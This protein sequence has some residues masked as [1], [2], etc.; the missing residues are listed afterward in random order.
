MMKNGF[1]CLAIMILLSSCSVIV[2]KIAHIKNPKVESSN[3]IINYLNKNNIPLENNYLLKGNQD[4]TTIYNNLL[5]G[6][7]SEILIFDKKGIKYCYQG[8]DKCTG[9][10]LKQA[11]VNFQNSYKPCEKDSTLL[12]TILTNFQPLTEDSNLKVSD[13]YLII[14]WNKYFGSKNKIGEDYTWLQ[15][16]KKDSDLD[17]SILLVNTDLQ[18]DW[19]LVEGKKMKIKFRLK[20]MKSASIEFGKIPYK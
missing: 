3:T 19:G 8:T 18:T 20:S 9:K 10:Q 7:K 16:M 1:Y 6:F 14:Y 15:T 11:Y 12:N 17:I 5:N 4:S 2:K 13:Y